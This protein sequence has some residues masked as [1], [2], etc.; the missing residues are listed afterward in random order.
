MAWQRRAWACVLYFFSGPFCLIL[1]ITLM[2]FSPLMK[3]PEPSL[4]PN[5]VEK[6][7]YSPAPKKE[8][9]EF[10]LEQE[11]VHGYSNAPIINTTRESLWVDGSS[12]DELCKEI[13]RYSKKS[14]LEEKNYIV[15]GYIYPRLTYETYYIS[16]SK[17]WTLGQFTVSALSKIYVPQWR[18]SGGA[19]EGT[20]KDWRDFK[21]HVE[22]HENYHQQVLEKYAWKLLE[23]MN[24]FGYYP[25][26]DAL[27]SA[28][29]SKYD[30]Y[31]D[32]LDKENE[33]FDEQYEADSYEE[34]CY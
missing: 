16:T 24:N 3:Q 4:V 12:R 11:P 18:S 14:G 31:Y 8:N 27:E 17:G 5:E 13:E 20:K 23:T 33:D 25:S 7:G 2:R 29:T 1:A 9:V 21:E 28:L 34:L 15:F 26:R 32:Q 6:I 22:D 10:A 19:S 30:N